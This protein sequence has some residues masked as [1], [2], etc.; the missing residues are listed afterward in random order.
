[1]VTEHGANSEQPTG[2]EVPEQAGKLLAHFAGYVGFKT[3]EMG[4]DNGLLAALNDHPEGLSVEEL[5]NA[6]GTEAFYTGVWASGAYGAALI[7]RNSDE[8]Y[9]LA[10][11]MDK[12]L[13]NPE[14]PG[15]VGGIINVFTQPEMFDRFNTNLPTGERTW[16]DKVSPEFI[17]GV[18]GT[19]LPFYN[20]LIPGGL[21]K[22]PGVVEKLEDGAAVLE[23]ASGAGRGLVKLAS[24]YPTAKITGLDGDAHSI[25]L[26]KARVDEAGV[27]DQVDYIQTTL[28][29]LDEQDKYDLVYINISMHEA[30]DIDLA[31]KNVL[32]ALKP[33]GVFVISDFPFPESHEGLRTIPARVMSGIQ[34]FEAQI[35]DQLVSTETFVKLLQGQGFKDVDSFLITPV[36]NVIYGTK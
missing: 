34:Y 6:A 9:V 36:H 21:S 2:P 24:T 12:L 33:G 20:R 14:F 30:R 31:T 4:L 35:D 15:Y 16:W 11:H 25:S 13:L 5:A 3:I 17:Q 8:K 1:V 27:S 29:D 26:A 18:S 22:V 32:N 10:P 7:E 28:E 23:L 19:G